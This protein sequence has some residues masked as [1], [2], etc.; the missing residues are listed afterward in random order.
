MRNV[1][2]T[3][4]ESVV[5]YRP[6]VGPSNQGVAPKGVGQTAVA[7]RGPSQADPRPLLAAKSR[8]CLAGARQAAVP[9]ALM[10]L[11]QRN[12]QLIGEVR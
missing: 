4:A 3:T 10:S 12:I 1:A 6:P 5:A 9:A 2:T 7:L 8:G 11:R